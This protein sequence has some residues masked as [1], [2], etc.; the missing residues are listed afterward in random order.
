M[1][2]CQCVASI[3]LICERASS[4]CWNAIYAQGSIY[5]LA[6]LEIMNEWMDE[7]DWI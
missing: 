4:T 3:Y 6:Q 7:L 2:V 5:P 1:H